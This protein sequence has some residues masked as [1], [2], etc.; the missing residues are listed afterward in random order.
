MRFCPPKKDLHIY[1]YVLCIAHMLLK[2]SWHESIRHIRE[3]HEIT[4]FKMHVHFLRF[5][6][7]RLLW[8]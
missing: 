2:Y 8:M 1:S 3:G 6:L 7:P 5:A 4:A